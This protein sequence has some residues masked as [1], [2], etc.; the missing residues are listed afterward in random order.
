MAWYS[1]IAWFFAGAFLAN[2]IPVQGMSG[3][4]FQ[5]PFA[6]PRGVGE[7]SAILN[8]IWGFINLAIC[9]VL[10]HVLFP[11]ELPPPWGLCLA[12]LIGAL[13]M[14]LYVA[15]YF[16][17]VGSAAS[18]RCNREAFVHHSSWPGMTKVATACPCSCASF[19]LLL[20][21]VVVVLIAVV[22]VRFTVFGDFHRLALL[23][24]KRVALGL[25]KLALFAVVFP[26]IE[27]HMQPRQHLIDRRKPAGRSWFA[28]RTLFAL[29]PGLSLRVRARRVCLARRACPVALVCRARRRTRAARDAPADRD[30]PARLLAGRSLSSL[31]AG[32]IVCHL[33]TADNQNLFLPDVRRWQQLRSRLAINRSTSFEIGAGRV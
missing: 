1:R 28:T 2:S 14:A 15:R 4:R 27:D 26:G 9:G 32:R 21:T 10:L 20:A 12:A 29:R 3:N 19:F 13:I 31:P 33:N 16:S 7:S 18:L 17:K 25:L 8:V 6:S 30:V 23:R 22:T 5:T 24:F 11:P